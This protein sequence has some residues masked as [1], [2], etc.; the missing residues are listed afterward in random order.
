MD[1]RR[2]KDIEHLRRIALAQQVQIEQLLRV[3]RAKCEELEAL[4]G[5]PEELQQTLALIETLTKK[6]RKRSKPRLRKLR[7]RNS[8]RNAKTSE[9]PSSR[10]CRSKSAYSSSMTPIA[11]ARAAAG[12]FPYPDGRTIRNV[13]D[14]RLHRDQ[15]TAS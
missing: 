2:E 9:R 4:K 8:R 10:G 5:N 11:R 6:F 14:D 15:F 3:L 7:R 1:L 13:G 12:R